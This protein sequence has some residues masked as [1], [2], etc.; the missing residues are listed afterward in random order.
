M[1]R[2][3]E[4]NG[5]NLV[6]GLEWSKLAGDKPADAAKRTAQARKCN[7]GVLW[8]V[9][10]E[11]DE[12]LSSKIVH[13][14]GLCHSKFK[15]PIY[16]GA[17]A[18]AMAQ[19]S[20]IGIEKLDDDLFWMI[21]TENGRVLPGY[22]SLG[23]EAEVKRKLTELA[24]DIQLDYMQ[25]Y[26]TS[27]VASLF[28]IYESIEESPLALIGKSTIS[29]AMRIKKLSSIPRAVYLGAGIVALGGGLFGYMQHLEAEKQREY[30]AM[31][32]AEAQ[33]LDTIEQEVT[34]E[35]VI[36]K[37]PT[38][39][40][41]LRMARQEEI[42][43]LRDDFNKVNRLPAMKSILLN[44]ISTPLSVN[45][46]NMKEVVYSNER[47]DAISIVWSRTYGSPSSLKRVMKGR[48]NTGFT[49][50]FEKASSTVKINIGSPGI[51]DILQVINEK[52]IGHQDFVSRLIEYGLKFDASVTESRQRKESI[53]GL[54]DK[55]LENMPQLEIASRTIFI[56]SDKIEDFVVAMSALENADN[57]LIDRMTFFNQGAG[58]VNW[59]IEGKLYE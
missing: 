1:E 3:V 18:L 26:M 40:D 5:K 44:F 57:Y 48:A 15:G 6:L 7:L 14:L 59:K 24:L 28:N 35:K 39:A 51:E 45:G 12:G 52:G 29:E 34:V 56:E 32:A 47:P 58:K 38:D 21:V 16:S 50:D 11:D 30:E 31:I 10:V 8:S 55:A 46:W 25:S 49:P 17:A 23:S 13:S 20:V 19:S 54:K 33:S 42:S 41:L 27:E 9:S 36:D 22:D 43:W 2:M 4:V 53:A 37:G